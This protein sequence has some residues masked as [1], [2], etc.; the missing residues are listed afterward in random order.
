MFAP[1]KRGVKMSR[2]VKNKTLINDYN[3]T[4]IP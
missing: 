1:P 2:W 4:E 3:Y